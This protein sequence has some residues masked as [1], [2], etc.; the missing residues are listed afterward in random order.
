MFPAAL[1]AIF[2]GLRISA[3]LSV[4]GAIVG[5]FFFG[6]GDA[7]IGQL[8]SK[9]ANQLD[10]EQL[11][12]AVIMSS[13]LGVAVFL[14]FGWVQHRAIG[15]W[16]DTGGPA[17][18]T[19]RRIHH[20][21]RR[22]DEP[23]RSTRSLAVLAVAGARRR[24]VRRR[25][26]ST[27]TRTRRH[28]GRRHGR[29]TAGDDRRRHGDDRGRRAPSTSPRVPGPAR[30]PDRLVP[31]GRARRALR[32]GR[33]GLHGRHRHSR[34][35][36]AR[37]SP[38]ARTRASTIEVRTGGPAIG[39]Q[40]VSVQ[41]YADDSIHL[42]YAN[43]EGQ[44][45]RYGETPVLSVVAPLEI[46]PQIIY[47]DPE[48][49][50]DVETLADL[51]EEDVTINVFAGGTFADVFVAEGIWNADQIDPSYDGS[52]ARFIAEDGAIAQ[53]GFASAE[54]YTYEN[55]FEEWGKPV[56][57]QTLHDAGFE[58]YSQTLSVVPDQL[59]ELRP[60]LEAFVPIVQQAAVDYIGD[61]DRANAIIID[62]VEQYDDFWVYDAGPRR[63]LGGDPARAR[64]RRQR[65][66]RHAR[67]HGRGAGPGRDRPDPRRRARR[68][69]G[70][71][72][73]RP[74]HQR[75]RRP[76]TS[77]CEMDRRH[78]TASASHHDRRHPRPL[79]PPRRWARPQPPVE[80]RSDRR[81]T[82]RRRQ[83]HARRRPRGRPPPSSSSRG[84]GKYL[85][86]DRR[87]RLE[88]L[89]AARVGPRA[90]GRGDRPP[91]VGPARPPTCPGWCRS[92][93]SSRPSSTAAARCA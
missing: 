62:A 20:Q 46:N 38:A 24:G 69:G 85:T 45:L 39:Y 32:D 52:P 42:G 7:G 36:A 22:S 86:D 76:A 10:G 1:P 9:Y 57:Y 15:K 80:P 26:R 47:W 68:A 27:A 51:G 79:R 55:V 64:V 53:Q 84:A 90:D 2:A 56:A 75:V 19:T 30:D 23:H 67:Q 87:R 74:R 34:S 72:R 50:P 37:S 70:P 78:A 5:D 92:A 71:D 8:L 77:D 13:L 48:T 16:Y 29:P 40:P 6:Q 28:D 83:G 60:C 58:V 18:M 63:L 66:R 44:V 17:A 41:Q 43:T 93:S 35:S 25:R 14:F 91:D 31:R 12:A 89:P 65:P 59:E 3:G 4:I 49:Y 61:P 11:F 73:R 81:R 54:P 88:G 21:H 82:G 33:R